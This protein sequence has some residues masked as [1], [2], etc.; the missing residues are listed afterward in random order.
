MERCALRPTVEMRALQAAD[1]V[2]HGAAGGRRRFLG[3][4]VEAAGNIGW[5]GGRPGLGPY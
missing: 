1:D 4:E 3:D 2:W 5:H